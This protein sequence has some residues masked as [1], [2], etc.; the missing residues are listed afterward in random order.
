MF[1]TITTWLSAGWSK[2]VPWAIALFSIAG[3]LFAVRQ[4]GINA[5]IAKDTQNEL[6][7]AQAALQVTQKVNALSDT[8]VVSQLRRYYRD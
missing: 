6:K 1:T 4:S 5:Q 7:A 3:G 2:L 8:D